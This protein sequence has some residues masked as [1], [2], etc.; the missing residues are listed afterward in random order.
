MGVACSICSGLCMSYFGALYGMITG[1]F[2]TYVVSVSNTSTEVDKELAR[3]LLMDGVF[4]TSMQSVGAGL[5]TILCQY[6]AGVMF[7]YSSVQQVRLKWYS[8]FENQPKNDIIFCIF[9]PHFQ[10]YSPYYPRKINK[11]YYFHF[12]Q[13]W[14]WFIMKFLI[15]DVSDT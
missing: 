12:I 3:S 1:H 11:Y 10:K 4:V 9:L 5:I 8:C 6:I 14:N 7:T 13:S 15:S 2:V